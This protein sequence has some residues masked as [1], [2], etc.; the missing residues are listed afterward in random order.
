MLNS[1]KSP[2]Q[3]IFIMLGQ[4]CNFNCK[5]CMQHAENGL[6]IDLPQEINPDIYEYIKHHAGQRDENDWPLHLHFYGGEPLIYF[7]NIKNIVDKVKNLHV[8]FSFISNGYAITQEMVD[9]FNKYN[10]TETISW[11]GYA[12]K[13]TRLIDVFSI[14]DK[15]RLLF[16]LKRLGVSA[17]YSAYTTP[18]QILDDFQK[19]SDEYQN[20]HPYPLHINIDE[21]FDTGVADRSLFQIDYEKISREMRELAEEYIRTKGMGNRFSARREYIRHIIFDRIDCR[22]DRERV[23]CS[24][25]NGYS[26]VNLDLSGTLYSCHNGPE[27][28]GTIYD[29]QMQTLTNLF[30]YDHT[31][32]FEKECSQCPIQSIC[33][34]GCKLMTAET[35][36]NT[37]CKLKRAVFLPVIETVLHPGKEYNDVK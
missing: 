3:T 26:T 20:I 6:H 9:F 28:I 13:D 18:I 24:C 23:F 27:A 4:R 31:M 29:N 33:Q 16:Q 8:S 10:F 17:V 25:G 19:L 7:D 35:R 1:V 32:E 15:K 14:P 11:D 37:Y 2:V 34:N 30:R 12:S 21:L 5:Y 36:K 22:E